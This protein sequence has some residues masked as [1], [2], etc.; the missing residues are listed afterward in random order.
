MN[1][2]ISLAQ[3]NELSA[4]NSPVI[5][6]LANEVKV[7]LTLVD[8]IDDVTIKSVLPTPMPIRK[9]GVYG[10][11]GPKGV[12]VVDPTIAALVPNGPV[13]KVIVFNDGKES[14]PVSNAKPHNIQYQFSIGASMNNEAASFNWDLQVSREVGNDVSVGYKFKTMTVEGHWISVVVARDNDNKI[15]KLEYVKY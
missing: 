15:N 12:F 2:V 14:K 4:L 13:G 10:D 6:S 11:W 7:R 5:V 1:L 3:F 9:N 8:T